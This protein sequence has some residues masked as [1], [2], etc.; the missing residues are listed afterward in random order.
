M[1]RVL[2]YSI[3]CVIFKNGRDNENSDGK[4]NQETREK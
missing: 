1:A 4:A 2:Q 3:L